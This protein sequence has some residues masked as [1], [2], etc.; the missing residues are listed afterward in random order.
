MSAK[1][2][3]VVYVVDDDELVRTATSRL[4]RLAGYEVRDYASA[5][6]FL[7]EETPAG[8]GCIVLDVLM[9]GP[10]GLDL[11]AA[12]TRRARPL[13]IVFLSGHG[14]I[15]MSVRAVKA[16]AVDF[17]TKPVD[18]NVLFAAV[19]HA[20]E[21]SVAEQATA[22]HLQAARAGFARLT[23]RE[24]E[25]FAEVVAGRLSKQIAHRLGTSERT[26]KAHRQQ[27]MEK[28]Q[29]SGL[30]ELGKLAELLHGAGDLAKPT[31]SDG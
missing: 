13:P 9:P 15:P 26:I 14:D 31:N 12:L 20:I 24:R 11:Q 3:P 4:L 27:I 19:A 6:E 21:Q 10:S 25:V 30:V 29:V 17:L 1:N 22:G 28:M 18:R 8:P 16:G 7:L 5:G 2:T 23:P